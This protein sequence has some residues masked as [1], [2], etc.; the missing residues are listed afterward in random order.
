MKKYAVEIIVA[1]VVGLAIVAGIWSVSRVPE[2]DPM[3]PQP[4]PDR[5]V[6]S[7]PDMPPY[8]PPTGTK[9]APGEEPIAAM[10]IPATK[11][12]QNGTYTVSGVLSLPTPCHE[13]KTE[14][15]ILESY[16]EQVVIEFTVVDSGGICVQVIDERPWTVQVK[17]S[18][19]ATFRAI[20]NGQAAVFSFDDYA[21]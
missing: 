12:Y 6:S 11:S 20:V 2:S 3:R 21:K 8:V 17:V 4:L 13:L 19:E 14:T 10:T 15:R 18:S 7:G 9:P 1:L 16:P 5:P